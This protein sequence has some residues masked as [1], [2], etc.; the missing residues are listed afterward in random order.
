MILPTEQLVQVYE[1]V[2]KPFGHPD[3]LGFMTRSLLMSEG[4]PDF[5]DVEGKQGFMPALPEVALEMT[6]ATE[7]QSLQG[8]LIATLTMDRMFFDKYRS[9]N[10]MMIAFHF[11]EDAALNE[12]SGKQ[13][14]LINDVNEAR[15][16][17]QDLMYP[18]MA[19]VNDVIKVLDQSRVDRRLTTKETNFFEYL[20]GVK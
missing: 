2:I 19:T 1:G 12:R 6:G 9:I 16:D 20:L 4:N 11:G 13:M 7:I 3:P 5:I 15:E 18:P 14:S 17:T 10:D 8:N